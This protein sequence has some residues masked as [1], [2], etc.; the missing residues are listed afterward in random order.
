MRP[1]SNFTGGCACL[2]FGLEYTMSS[3]AR[4][5][6]GN[7]SRVIRFLVNKSADT[8]HQADNIDVRKGKSKTVYC[9]S[10]YLT[11]LM[12]KKIVSQ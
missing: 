4:V 1:G 3:E 10:Q 2:R 11:N 6:T 8:E 5:A 12:Q 9:L 7:K